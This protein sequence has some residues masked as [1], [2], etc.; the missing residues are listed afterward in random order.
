MSEVN[1]QQADVPVA[2]NVLFNKKGTAPGMWFKKGN[3][4]LAV[5]PGIP[6]EMKY[7]LEHPVRQKIGENF[8]IEGVRVSDYYKSAG[9]PESELS[10]RAG[11]LSQYIGNGVDV[12]YL[13]HP[14]GV[15]IRISAHGSNGYIAEEKLKVLRSTL[16]ERVGH[17]IFGQG[18]ESDLA[19]VV[20]KILTE[21]NLT[22]AVAESCTG[23]LL[24]S[25]ITDIPG[26]AGYMKGSVTAYCNEIKI[27]MLDVSPAVLETH[28]AVSKLTAMQMA[29]GVA[30]KMDSDIGVSTTGIAG[31]GGG[32]PE[33]PVGLVWMGFWIMGE[34][35]ALK[36]NFSEDRLINK[37]RTVT[38]VL[39]TL[40]RHFNQI[41]EMPYHL[42]PRRL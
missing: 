38:V 12:A 5:L 41:D 19:D 3:H 29:K 27:K 23:G 21:R 33:K 17:V 10:E 4:Y 11:D 18:K 40:R 1:R 42:K 32:T 16:Q 2:S 8:P 37:E 6:H 14:G 31:P 20:G 22:I 36:A 35:F 24:S 7:L 13:P 9:V 30:E 25:R 26:C 28:G 34:H 15:N 39:E